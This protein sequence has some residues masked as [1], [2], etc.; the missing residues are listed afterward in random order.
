MHFPVGPLA[1]SAGRHYW[2]TVR[3]VD[4]TTVDQKPYLLVFDAADGPGNLVSDGGLDSDRIAAFALDYDDAPIGP[5]PEST[6]TYSKAGE[7]ERVVHVTGSRSSVLVVADT[8]FPGWKAT[9]DGR[10]AEVLWADRAF[11]G[12]EVPR[13][14]HTV[15]F[16]YRQPGAVMAGYVIS[17]VTLVVLLAMLLA[18]ARVRAILTSASRRSRR[19]APA[20]QEAAEGGAP[21]G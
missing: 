12:V 16:D 20:L 6:L 5:A 13:G 17:G 14:S 1:G 21:T 4:C 11:V 9:V 18:P 2:F 10:S 15:V 19:A 7:G 3:C 8:R